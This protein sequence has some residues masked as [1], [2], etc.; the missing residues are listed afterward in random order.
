MCDYKAVIDSELDFLGS[1]FIL[2]SLNHLKGMTEAEARALITYITKKFR[3]I[4]YCIRGEE[5]KNIFMEVVTTVDYRETEKIDIDAFRIV[6]AELGVDETIA[7]EITCDIFDLFHKDVFHSKFQFS[8]KTIERLN[9]LRELAGM[10]PVRAED[11][12]I[13]LAIYREAH[14]GQQGRHV[15]FLQRDKNDVYKPIEPLQHLCH[16][17]GLPVVQVFKSVE[18][19]VATDNLLIREQC[20][21]RWLIQLAV[22]KKW[23][24][25]KYLSWVEEYMLEQSVWFGPKAMCRW[26]IEFLRQDEG[27]EDD[28]HSM[29]ARLLWSTVTEIFAPGQ[30]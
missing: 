7:E 11:P 1:S 28:N 26:S 9:I 18:S 6:V 8:S 2:R 12:R 27:I 13:A 30:T 23:N 24:R 15:P 5:K 20:A 25:E 17:F 21:W 4:G 16:D 22:N 3:S 14:K 10:P 19:I 29:A